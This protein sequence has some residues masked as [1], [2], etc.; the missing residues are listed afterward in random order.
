MRLYLP[1]LKIY[2]KFR[3]LGVVF[4]GVVLS[5]EFGEIVASLNF[6]EFEISG[7]LSYSISKFSIIFGNPFS[8]FLEDLET[9]DF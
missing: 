9:L 1:A 8:K 4:R 5:Y 6:S 3:A 7:F 2:R